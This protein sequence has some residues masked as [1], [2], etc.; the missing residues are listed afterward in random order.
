MKHTCCHMHDSRCEDVE[1]QEHGGTFWTMLLHVDGDDGG[2][3]VC[4]LYAKIIRFLGGLAGFIVL[5][6][7]GGTELMF[8]E[9]SMTVQA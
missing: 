9:D 8:S 7:T 5:R 4:G 2:D 1:R 6:R 3:M